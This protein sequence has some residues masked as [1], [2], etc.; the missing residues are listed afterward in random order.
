MNALLVIAPTAVILALSIAQ[1]FRLSGELQTLAAKTRELQNNYKSTRQRLR[2]KLMRLIVLQKRATGEPIPTVTFQ[3]L[4]KTVNALFSSDTIYSIAEDEG[5]GLSGTCEGNG[6]CGLCTV[7]ILSGAEHISPL[8][9]EEAEI[10]KKLS[11]P[12]GS[13]LSCQA[14]LS[15]GDVALDFIDY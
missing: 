4:G 15:G 2:N 14:R 5:F 13:R 9:T 12:P 8:S 6:D 7:A 3:K 11:R 1:A 10:L